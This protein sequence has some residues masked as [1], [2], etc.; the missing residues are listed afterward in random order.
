VDA[1]SGERVAGTVPGADEAAGD[2][3]EREYPADG[4]E[5]VQGVAG[6][7]DLVLAP[8]RVGVDQ[9]AVRSALG[10][11]VVEATVG[12]LVDADASSLRWR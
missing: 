10:L 1:R 5:V 12:E 4:V 8:W 11:G 9:R 7:G 3:L 6:V 2:A